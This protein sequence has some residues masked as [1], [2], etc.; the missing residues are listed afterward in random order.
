[1]VAVGPGREHIF[2]DMLS[3]TC[4]LPP[5]SHVLM[6]HSLMSLSLIKVVPL[7]PLASLVLPAGIKPSTHALLIAGEGET[8][9]VN[10]LPPS[11]GDCK[12]KAMYFKLL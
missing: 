9:D 8:A 12:R 3:T 5:T 10:S 6:A 4:I 1:M 7:S 2:V 11:H